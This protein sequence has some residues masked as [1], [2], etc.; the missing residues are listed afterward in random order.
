MSNNFY[1]NNAIAFFNDTVVADLTAV[2]QQF[3]PLLT[4]NSHILDAGCGS[5]RDTCFFIKKGFQV[6]AFDASEA[7][8]VKA[9][10]YTGID[11]SLNT[12]EKFQSKPPGFLYDAIWACASL[13][14]VPSNK[15]T[16][17]FTNLAGQLK[18]GGIFYCSFKYGNNDI[19]RN[20]RYFT[21]ADE[22]RLSMFI[23]NTDLVI[24]KT[25][26]TDDVRP[27]R[28]DEKWLNAILM[29]V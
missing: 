20:G 13:L 25:W 6:T 11:V 9:S 29:K 1:N 28:H 5:G 2:Y 7:L 21:N 24:D 12:F 26:I 27:D 17:S 22:V 15:I 4:N 3:L 19:T 18:V 14:H 8:V 23:K 10:E 16:V